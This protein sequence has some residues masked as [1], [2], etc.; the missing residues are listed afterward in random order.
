VNSANVDP[1][2]WDE[3]VAAR[4]P[5]VERARLR[6]VQQARMMLDAAKRLMGQRGGD[7]TIQEVAKEAGVAL[8]TFYNYFTSKDELL[9][10]MIGDLLTESCAR[11]AAAAG[12]LPDP[13]TRLRYYITSAFDT[14]DGG[15]Q[16][17]AAAA[18]ITTSHWR[19]HRVFPKELAAA[20][21]PFVELLRGEIRASID[22]GLLPPTDPY[23]NGWLLNELIRSVYHHY[24]Y[25][26]ER[27]PEVREELWRFCLQALGGT[28]DVRGTA[29]DRPEDDS[30]QSG[31]QP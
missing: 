30:P 17:V 21:L 6:T 24:V 4:S 9:L 22:V 29:T 1:V 27:T 20:Q 23:W 13:L 12:D 26:A 3:R 5:S 16:D 28:T 2:S 8:Q 11:W 15:G 31:G 25:T 18:F 19:L 7:F 14:L 10:A